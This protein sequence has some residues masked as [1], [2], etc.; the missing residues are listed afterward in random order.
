M[1]VGRGVEALVSVAEDV[2]RL[3]DE[4][5]DL[6]VGIEEEFQLLDSESL[7]LTGRFEELRRLADARFAAPLV[8]GELIQS[9]AEV[10]TDPGETFADARADLWRRRLALARAADELG[11][12]L[13]STGVHPYSLWEDQQFIDSP[14][15]QRVVAGLQYVAW[16]N[17]TF[18]M[19]VHVGVRG[20]DRAIAVCDAFRTYL[21]TLLALS[22]SSPFHRGYRTGLHTTRA[23]VFLRSFPR[24]GIPDAYGD[25]EA[26]ADYAEFL[27]GTGS[28]REP[29][30]I[31]WTLR[32]HHLYGTMEVRIADAQPL[33]AD[34]IGLAG[35]TVALV[36]DLME[37]H[38][39]GEQLPVY[40]GR[41]LEENRWRA[42]RN[43]LSGELI[44]LET[45]RPEPAVDAVRR[46]VARAESRAAELGVTAELERVEDLLQRGN[47]A[48]RQIEMYA[49]GLDLREIH[50]R[51]VAETMG[52]LIPPQVSR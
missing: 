47:W 37:R 23:Q 25:W 24:C 35:L 28:V 15:Y 13:G 1:L 12:R 32:A 33:F 22:A 27:Y 48:Q 41:F 18:G 34:S 5:R 51:M 38:D 4:G 40:A 30:Q 10:K 36:G 2:R 39:R 3:F 29:T 14:H 52:E 43:G 19:H 26:Y 17:N 9:E 44:D 50:R 46:L 20:A 45:G 8:V 16:T 49:S 31:W 6:T 42:V 11:M 21:P 7:E